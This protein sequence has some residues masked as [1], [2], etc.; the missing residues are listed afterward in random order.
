MDNSVNQNT[1]KKNNSLK[2]ILNLILIRKE[3]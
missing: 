3:I 2:T 1:I